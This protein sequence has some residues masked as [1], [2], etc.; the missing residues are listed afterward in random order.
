LQGVS[1]FRLINFRNLEHLP[2]KT[3][4]KDGPAN[5][6]WQTCIVIR[7]PCF[8]CALILTNQAD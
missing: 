6:G 2:A 7:L 8:A 4:R 1:G 3:S 5:Q